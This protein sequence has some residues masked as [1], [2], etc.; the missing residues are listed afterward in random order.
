LALNEVQS[1]MEFSQATEFGTGILGNR[2]WGAR[3]WRAASLNFL[4]ALI[5]ITDLPALPNAVCCS[6]VF[7]YQGE[8]FRGLFCVLRR[9]HFTM[10]KPCLNAYTTTYTTTTRL[11]NVIG[12]SSKVPEGELPALPSLWKSNA[13]LSSPNNT[14]RQ[15]QQISVQQVIGS[16]VGAKRVESGRQRPTASPAVQLLTQVETAHSKR[17]STRRLRYLIKAAGRQRWG[18][19]LLTNKAGG[20]GAQVRPESTYSRHPAEHLL[21]GQMGGRRSLDIE[22]A[23]EAAAASYRT[24]DR[25][26]RWVPLADFT[27]RKTRRALDKRL[28]TAWVATPPSRDSA[29]PTVSR[30]TTIP[31]DTA[32][33]I[34]TTAARCGRRLARQRAVSPRRSSSDGERVRQSGPTAG[35]SAAGRRRQRLR[36]EASMEAAEAAEA[37]QDQLSKRR[38]WSLARL[39][40]WRS[41][42]G[43]TPHRSAGGGLLLQA[44]AVCSR[45]LTGDQGS[46]PCFWSRPPATRAP[47]ALATLRGNACFLAPIAF[48]RVR[49]TIA[50][51]SVECAVRPN[52]HR[53]NRVQARPALCLSGHLPLQH[54]A[55]WRPLTASASATAQLP[56][57]NCSN[58]QCNC[59]NYQCHCS[60]CQCP[61]SSKL[62]ECHCSNCQC[63]CSNC[64]CHCC[65]A[66]PSAPFCPLAEH[67]PAALIS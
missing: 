32:K 20:Q 65:Q 31:L 3:S 67:D 30:P 1:L 48:Q 28:P 44:A 21:L 50:P 41:R 56:V 16:Q 13:T 7:E 39:Q 36:R 43:L 53:R 2:N 40:R 11:F 14:K 59:S 55:L 54:E 26:L 25:C 46:C 45:H 64:Q 37:A 27:A 38:P 8:Q 66:A 19:N 63:H 5:F 42:T 6:L 57:P 52:C 33:R 15:S 35:G 10:L 18:G 12:L 51:C 58:Y 61:D 17:L 62:P 60:N 22:G 4:Q 23:A 24:V 47:D 34:A 49:G 9:Q 29:A